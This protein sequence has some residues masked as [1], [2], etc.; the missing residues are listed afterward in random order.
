MKV[1]DQSKEISLNTGGVQVVAK[2]G[3]PFGTFKALDFVRDSL[4]RI[5]VNDQGAPVAAVD[6]SYFGSAQEKY[7]IGLGSTLSWKGLSVNVQFDIKKGGQFYS[8]TKS[9][10]DFNGTSLT[11]MVNGREP[12]VVPNSVVDNGDG[13]YS[14]NTTPLTNLFTMVGSYPESQ[15]LIDASY[16][17]LRE[18]SISYTLEKKY[19]KNVPIQS[20][21]IGL[22]GRNLKFWLPKENVFADPESN[23]FGQNGNVQGMEFSQTPPT[24][25]IGFDFRIQ[26]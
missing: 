20:I 10:G 26:F 3:M 21:S 4:G 14:P 17:K 24:R 9:A 25:S 18:A 8:G 5:V 1:S 7:K 19:L 12:Y 23:S 6:Y 15:D 16:I 13:T 22:V 11:S 2:E